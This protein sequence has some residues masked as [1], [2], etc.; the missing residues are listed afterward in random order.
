[1]LHYGLKGLGSD[2]GG[3]TK[4][5]RRVSLYSEEYFFPLGQYLSQLQQS[6]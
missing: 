4:R 5:E 6:R 3:E 1:M 2:V